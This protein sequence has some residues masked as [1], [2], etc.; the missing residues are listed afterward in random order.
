[1][2]DWIPIL[3][4]PIESFLIP[5]FSGHSLKDIKSVAIKK[6]SFLCSNCLTFQNDILF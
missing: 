2:K 5:V 6:G 1:M 4:S 3:I